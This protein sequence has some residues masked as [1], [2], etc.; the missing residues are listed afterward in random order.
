MP[1]IL[2]VAVVGSEGT[3]APAQIVSEVPKLNVGVMFGLTVTVNVAGTAHSPAVGVNVY[4]PEVWLST[5]AA[6]HV[7]VML[8]SDV[9]GSVGTVPPSHIISDVPKL[10]VGIMF[11]FTVTVKVIGKAQTPA[12]GVNVYTPEAWLSTVDGLHVPLIALS[13]VAG[14]VG[15]VPPA[16]MVSVV[17]KLNVGVTLGVTVTVNVVDT[18]HWPAVGVNV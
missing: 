13:D 6:L 15:T 12:A 5:V 9:N 2:F 16:H 10:N 3:S 17:P 8:L 4:V 1:E 11:G 7:P 14:S 18:A